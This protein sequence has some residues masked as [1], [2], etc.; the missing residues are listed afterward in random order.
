MDCNRFS[1]SLS[2]N[3][4]CFC[5]LSQLFFFVANLRLLNFTTATREEK[6]IKMDSLRVYK[7][8]CMLY[9]ELRLNKQEEI[10]KKNV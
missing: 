8:L 2:L 6:A 10:I 3:A 9:T 1:L 4:S 5:F 7:V